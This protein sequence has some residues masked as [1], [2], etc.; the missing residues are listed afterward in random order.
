MQAVILAAGKGLRLRPFTDKHPKPLIDISGQPLLEHTLASLPDQITEVIIVIGYLGEQIE[1]HFGNEWKG[2]TIRYVTQ[3]ELLGTGDALLRAKN[4]L[5]RQ[6]LVINGDDLYTKFD[7]EK[8]VQNPNSML[9]WSSQQTSTY[10]IV[11]NENGHFAG[12][13]N[14]STLINCGAYFLDLNFFEFPLVSV[15]VPNGVEYSLPHT[16]ATIANEIPV[17]LVEATR[18]LP[19]GTPEQL[20]FANDYFTRKPF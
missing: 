17:T 1:E 5:D 16:L 3:T 13:D 19:V 20:K 4:L 2:K 12:F 15:P 8:M 6:F 18:W 10:G 11:K 7:L 14:S 9:V